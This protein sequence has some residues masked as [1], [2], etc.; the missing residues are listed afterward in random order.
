M[1]GRFEPAHFECPFSLMMSSLLRLQLVFHALEVQVAPDGYFTFEVTGG[2]EPLQVFSLSF[3]NVSADFLQSLLRN[4][5][6][7]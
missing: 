3:E 6:T 2:Q 7:D 1:S 4:L 5:L